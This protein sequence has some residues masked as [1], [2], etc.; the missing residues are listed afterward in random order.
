[1]KTYIA[2]ALLLVV[3]GSA[4]AQAAVN[5][6]VNLDLPAAVTPL[7]PQAFAGNYPPVPP[8]PTAPPQLVIDEPPRFIYSPNLGFYVSV[9]IPYDIA[10]INNGYYLHN[11]GYWYVAPSYWGPWSSVPQRRLPL[12]LRKY[13]Y[14]QIRHFRDQEYRVFQH[15]REH[16][17]GNWYRPSGARREEGREGRGE[18]RDERRDDRREDHRGGPERH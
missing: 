13:R 8:P 5:F 15:D 9:D 7:P 4:T 10:Y 14:Q 1:M 16:Y 6:N 3:A 11:G 2:A 17:R 12:G 18:R